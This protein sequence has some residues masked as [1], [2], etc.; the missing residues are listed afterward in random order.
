MKKV[1]L[2]SAFVS[3]LRSG[4]EACAE[5]VAARLQDRYDITIVAARMR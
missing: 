5:E 4:A 3:P 1:V 2:F